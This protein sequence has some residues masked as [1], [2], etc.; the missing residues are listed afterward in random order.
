MLHSL[1][2]LTSC[3]TQQQIS[4]VG[5]DF[6]LPS[7]NPPKVIYNNHKFHKISIQIL[8]EWK[9]IVLLN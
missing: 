6:W 2:N 3:L 7:K 8:H 1:R 4:K 9:E 5:I